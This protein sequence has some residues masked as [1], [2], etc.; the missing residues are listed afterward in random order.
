MFAVPEILP[1]KDVSLI[2]E[3]QTMGD[4]NIVHVEREQAL[5]R[6]LVFFREVGFLKDLPR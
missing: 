5:F 3:H 1:S 4:V 6:Q 2:S